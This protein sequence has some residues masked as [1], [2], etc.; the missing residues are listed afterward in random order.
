MSSGSHNI[1]PDIYQEQHFWGAQGNE[2]YF[3]KRRS[4][5]ESLYRS[6]KFF[7]P[8]ILRQVKT[9][10]D[11]GCACGDF[12]AIMKSYHPGLRYTGVDIIPRFIELAKAHYPDSDFYVSDGVHMDFPDRA[13]DL[14][15]STGIIHLN[16]RYQDIF[17]EMYRV[18]DKY[19]L[20]DFRLTQ[21]PTVIGEMDV[22]INDAPNGAGCLPYYVLNIDDHLE[23]LRSLSPSPET[24]EIKGYL[25]PPTQAA[26]IDTK[27]IYMA[28]FLIRKPV[29]AVTSKP[30]IHIN[31]N[32]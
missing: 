30:E 13:F 16:S 21:G 14:L 32:A 9:C 31:L 5:P 28:F 18:A 25:H 15:H 24:I 4:A 20:C 12:N 29:G 2:E 1:D 6:E 19:I 22:H 26:R 3:K 17:R 27:E 23:F 11:I 7:L 8:D 10:L